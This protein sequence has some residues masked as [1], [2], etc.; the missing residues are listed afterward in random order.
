L[1]LLQER[2]TAL[3]GTDATLTLHGVE[4]GTRAELSLPIRRQEDV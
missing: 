3:Y 4:G 1:R 2:L